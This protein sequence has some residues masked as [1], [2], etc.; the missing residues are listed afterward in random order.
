[1]AEIH[2]IDIKMDNV[3]VNLKISRDEYELLGHNTS[4]LLL[5]PANLEFLNRPLTTGKL[6]NSN[7][8]MLPKKILEKFEIKNLV[9]KAPARTFRVDDEVFLLIKLKGSSLGIPKFKE[10]K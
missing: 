5:L 8:I 1:M 9:K 4:E 10:V 2:S 3:I 7:R 6:G